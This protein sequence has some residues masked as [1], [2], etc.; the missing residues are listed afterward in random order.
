MAHQSREHSPEGLNFF[1]LLEWLMRKGVRPPGDRLASEWT[2]KELAGE[3]GLTLR[4]INY[5]FGSKPNPPLTSDL[6]TLE[7]V[8]FGPNPEHD[9]DWYSI[10]RGKLRACHLAEHLARKPSRVSTTKNQS[11]VTPDTEGGGDPGEEQAASA[12]TNEKQPIPSNIPFLSLKD[13]MKGRDKAFAE[14]DAI[15][16]RSAESGLSGV[17][18]YGLGGIGKTR[19]SVEYALKSLGRYKALLFVRADTPEL[20]AADFSSLVGGDILNL[21][22]QSMEN[23]DGRARAVRNWLRSHPNWLMIFD[24]VDDAAAVK[25]VINLIKLLS[26]GHYIINGRYRNYPPSI[27]VREISEIGVEDS[28]E[29][30]LKRT[31]G[32]RSEG[33]DDATSARS[34]AIELGGLPLALE[35][36]AAYIAVKAISFNRYTQLWNRNREEVIQWSDPDSIEY[37]HHAGLAATWLTSIKRISRE[38][39]RLL[40]LLAFF[41]PIPIPNWLLDV[42]DCEDV[43][44]LID[45]RRAL[46]EL[47]AYSLVSH[48]TGQWDKRLGTGFYVHRMVQDFT[49]RQLSRNRALSTQSAAKV[50]I[51]RAPVKFAIGTE[52]LGPGLDG[53]APHRDAIGVG[54][55]ATAIQD[56]GLGS[57]AHV[58]EFMSV[59]P[60]LSFEVAAELIQEL[61]SGLNSAEIPSDELAELLLSYGAL[62]SVYRVNARVRSP[63]EALIT[64]ACLFHEVG[65]YRLMAEAIDRVF[66]SRVFIAY[67]MDG[68]A[69]ISE[70]ERKT[71]Y[72]WFAIQD[73]HRHNGREKLSLLGYLIGFDLGNVVEACGRLNA[74]GRSGDIA[75]YLRHKLDAALTVGGRATEAWKSICNIIEGASGP[76]HPFGFHAADLVRAHPEVFAHSFAGRAVSIIHKSAKESPLPSGPYLRAVTLDAWYGIQVRIDHII[77]RGPISRAMWEDVLRDGD[78]AGGGGWND[79]GRRLRLLVT[80]SD[81]VEL[82]AVEDE[83]AALGVLAAREFGPHSSLERDALV[84][85][86][87]VALKTNR[88]GTAGSLL[89]QALQITNELA[90]IEGLGK[91]ELIRTR[92]A[93]TGADLANQMEVEPI[94]SGATQIDVGE[95]IGTRYPAIVD[96]GCGVMLVVESI[97]EVD[98]ENIVYWRRYFILMGGDRKYYVLDYEVDDVLDRLVRAESRVRIMRKMCGTPLPEL[99]GLLYIERWPK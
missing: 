63:V 75:A 62:A 67:G 53:L 12:E 92:L 13:L 56:S 68:V 6:Q 65:K 93:D 83:A 82:K 27:C 35:Q 46:S 54:V 16:C 43:T 73:D 4:A 40:S 74:D 15:L 19:L 3:V 20:L 21:P 59:R 14:I 37:N 18:L 11:V 29:F 77:R 17:A 52:W 78:L 24:N 23:Q 47:F 76:W 2:R 22:E 49:R 57:R 36:A 28:T 26:G 86:A 71:R 32:L 85:R 9:D 89:R 91:A 96:K 87:D 60:I 97:K 33:P 55:V 44:G 99:E 90:V 58:R 38:S 34:L 45:P 72:L 84:L 30:L 94:C 51:R 50:W 66:H 7:R 61:L 69:D 10:E 8:F 81:I 48:G 70:I 1:R 25:A 79:I 64:A 31:D 98:I 80:L 5:W 88:Q 41:A 39:W 42:E 95:F